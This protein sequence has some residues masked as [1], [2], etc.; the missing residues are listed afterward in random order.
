MGLGSLAK[1]RLSLGFYCFFNKRPGN[2]RRE[3]FTGT[4]SKL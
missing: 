4:A 1:K 2:K 3:I